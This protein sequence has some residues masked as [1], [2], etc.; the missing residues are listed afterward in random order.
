MS[1]E[2]VQEGPL[3]PAWL[4]AAARLPAR[5]ALSREI[6]KLDAVGIPVLVFEPTT[7]VL[8]QMGLQPMDFRRR[9]PVAEAAIEAAR[10]HLDGPAGREVGRVLMKSH[11]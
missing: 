8:D 1:A 4:R 10:S 9:A 3:S 2:R 5:R 6:R 11:S 7:V